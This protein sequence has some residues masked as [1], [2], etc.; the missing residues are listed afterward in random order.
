[1]NDALDGKNVPMSYYE[2]VF[3]LMRSKELTESEAENLLFNIFRSQYTP[4]EVVLEA[5]ENYEEFAGLGNWRVSADELLKF[6]LRARFKRRP[7]KKFLQAMEDLYYEIKDDPR[8]FL[9]SGDN[10]AK[11]RALLRKFGVK[12]NEG[13]NLKALIKQ[14]INW[15]S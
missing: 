12:V 10:Q 11:S 14:T 9:T 13:M 5:F 7:S 4:E 6:A 15:G 1:M 3:E 8:K 2:D